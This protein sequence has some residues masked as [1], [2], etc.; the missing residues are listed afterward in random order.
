[1]KI[2][3]F[4][5][6]IS[7]IYLMIGLL[8]ILFSDKILVSIVSDQQTL[9][10][11]Q[12]M[13]GSFFVL[14]TASILLIFIKSHMAKLKKVEEELEVS[15]EKYKTLYEQTPIAYQSLSNDGKIIDINPQW[16]YLLGYKRE[17]VTGKKFETLI[18]PDD[19]FLFTSKSSTFETVG[20]LHDLHLRIKKKDNTYIH[21]SFEGLYGYDA[22]KKIKQSYYTFKN[23]TDAY[24]AKQQLIENEKALIKAKEKAEESD[25]L[26][27]AFLANLSHEIRTPLNGI[28]GFTELLKFTDITQEK[29]DQYID[30]V[31]S[32]GNY[33]LEIIND[34]IEIAHIEAKQ[35]N[36]KFEKFD[37]NLLSNEIESALRVAIPSDKNITLINKTSLPLHQATIVSDKLKLKQILNNLLSNAIKYTSEGNISFGCQLNSNKNIHFFVKD[38]GIGI[39]KEHQGI[40]FDRFRQVNHKN[41]FFQSGSGLGLA[42]T[43]SYVDLMG[44]EIWLESEFGKGSQFHFTLPIQSTNTAEENE[45]E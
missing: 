24:L 23:V 40:I 28:L 26:K 19:V 12:S 20:F 7:I 13:K 1:M 45:S 31:Y 27:S 36:T 16:I 35:V 30:I 33:L 5:Y 38:E 22:N 32:N 14:T 25:Q 41:E 11:I 44:G 8:W 39:R 3:Q 18:H 21:A 29:R 10:S 15:N 34:I 9:T 4:E 42:I 17:E 6:R 2:I 43:K 37:I